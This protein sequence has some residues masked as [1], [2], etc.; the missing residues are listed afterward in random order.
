MQY[1][2]SFYGSNLDSST[3]DLVSTGR[4]V[5]LHDHGRHP[6]LAARHSFT[7][8][9]DWM[10]NRRIYEANGAIRAN[11]LWSPNIMQS[12]EYFYKEAADVAKPM[13]LRFG[14]F[15][16]GGSAGL[17]GP[18]YKKESGEFLP[19]TG[20]NRGATFEGDQSKLVSSWMDVPAVSDVSIMSTSEGIVSPANLFVERESTG[21][22]LEVQPTST[23]QMGLST[24]QGGVSQNSLSV[25]QY[26]LLGSDNDRYRFVLLPVHEGVYQVE[27]IQLIQPLQAEGLSKQHTGQRQILDLRSM[28]KATSVVGQE[29]VVY[30]NPATNHVRIVVNM[31]GDATSATLA[32]TAA[33]VV[34]TDERGGEMHRSTCNVVDALSIDTA[35]WTTGIYNVRVMTQQTNGQQCVK[36]QQFVVVR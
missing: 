21:E 36:T 24:L 4:L 1:G 15:R 10:R 18:I 9:A 12:S 29:V 35:A 17:I 6:H 22:L 11:Y 2:W 34:I 3:A 25:S 5:G 23:T 13:A 27:D 19:L 16:G 30:P 28:K 33:S 14:G 8:G 20:E 32:P 31:R 26:T 7:Q